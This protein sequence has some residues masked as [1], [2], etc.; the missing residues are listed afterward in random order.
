M[1]E[2]I[3]KAYL[4]LLVVVDEGAASLEDGQVVVIPGEE[5]VGGERIHRQY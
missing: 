5:N 2:T 3:I 4:V 1:V